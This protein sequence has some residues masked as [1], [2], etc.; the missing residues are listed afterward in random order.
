MDRALADAHLQLMNQGIQM[1]QMTGGVTDELLARKTNAISG[2]AIKQRQEQGSLVTSLF[3]K[4]FYLLINCR[5][6]CGSR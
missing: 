3:L 2:V 6:K 5:A 4:I 1:I